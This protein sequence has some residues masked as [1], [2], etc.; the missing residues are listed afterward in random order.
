MALDLVEAGEDLE[1][2]QDLSVR[3]SSALPPEVTSKMLYQDVIYIAW[4]SMLEMILTQLASMVDL[5]MV[6]QLGAWAL[7]SVGL[8]TQPKF[9]MMTLI[10]AL[11]VG[12]TAM[13]ARYKGAANPEKANAILRQAISM[14]FVLSLIA[15]V[16]GYFA[17]EPLV[18][19]M[20]ASDAESLAGGTAYLQIQMVGFVFLGLTTTATATLRGVGDS[21]TAMVY[22]M[23]ANAV[24]VVL[25]YLLIYGNFGFPRM[26]VA[27][28]SLATIIGQFVAFILAMRALFSGK[29]YICLRLKDGFR[30][31]REAIVSI[32]K[33]GIPAMI[34]QLIMRTGMIIY[35]KTVA[36]LGTVAYATHNVCMNLQ[37]M[38]FMIGQAIAVS[39]TSLVGQS[40]G[41]KRPDMAQF[42]STRARRIGLVVSLLLGAIFFFFGRSIVAL[43][44]GDLDI[45]KTGGDIM[46]IVAFILPFQSSQFILAGAL[47][48]AGDT[49]SIAKI[50]FVTV[51]LVRPG[52]AIL[53]VH[54]LGI[55]IWGAWIAL[56]LDQIIRSLLVLLRYNSGKWKRVV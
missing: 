44:T 47:R 15:S 2:G 9:L 19:F 33:V 38:S 54:V 25:N 3:T 4:P 52:I 35:A 5:M 36:S 50:T 31:N 34:E 48:G 40:L 23:I 32:A 41:K 12:A 8:T 1:A 46:R 26:E 29:N 16:I 7:T 28:A 51:L 49:K 43:Y 6:G 39:A 37:Q 30:P 22:N 18:R 11:N 10:M 27:G 55:G 53:G 21:R 45:I 56:F 20:G 24:N 14:T 13:V 17:A 42:Y